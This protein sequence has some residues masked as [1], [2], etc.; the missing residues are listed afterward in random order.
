[1]DNPGFGEG[2][3]EEITR[4]AETSLTTSS[5]YVHIMAYT[6]LDDEKDVAALKH[7]YCK[8]KGK[9]ISYRHVTFIA[10]IK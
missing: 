4:E 2:N 1:M 3:Q 8:D 10:S 6:H 7:I 5:A 9:P